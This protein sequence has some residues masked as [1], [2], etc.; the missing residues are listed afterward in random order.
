MYGPKG[1]SEVSDCISR[2]DVPTYATSVPVGCATPPMVT[3]AVK[4][5]VLA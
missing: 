1:G 2:T 5:I 3:R 4:A